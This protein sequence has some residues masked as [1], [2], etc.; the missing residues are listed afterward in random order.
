MPGEAPGTDHK[1][2]RCLPNSVDVT[3]Q[4]AGLE[5]ATRIVTPATSIRINTPGE[6]CPVDESQ[7]LTLDEC[8]VSIFDMVLLIGCSLHLPW[9][10]VEPNFGIIN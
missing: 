7:G 10:L 5:L 6:F 2:G 8:H 9:H 1:I 4:T 3:S